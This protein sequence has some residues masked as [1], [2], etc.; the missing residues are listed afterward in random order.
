M[1]S[2][3]R[4]VELKRNR[5]LLYVLCQAEHLLNHI[6]EHKTQKHG[7]TLI[8]PCFSFITDERDY[9]TEKN[10]DRLSFLC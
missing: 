4:M 9:F 7:F 1:K 10:I 3:R 6:I 2:W 5:H 8:K